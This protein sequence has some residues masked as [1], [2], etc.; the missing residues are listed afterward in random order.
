MKIVE[1]S[2]ISVASNASGNPEKGFQKGASNNLP[3]ADAAMM[4]M[5]FKNYVDFTSAEIR[6]VKAAR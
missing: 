5:Y 3:K 6:G 2:C 4:A 1:N